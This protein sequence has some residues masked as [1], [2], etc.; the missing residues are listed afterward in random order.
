[1]SLIEDEFK[2]EKEVLP[3]I[4]KICFSLNFST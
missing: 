1:M 4:L 3:Y 2:Q